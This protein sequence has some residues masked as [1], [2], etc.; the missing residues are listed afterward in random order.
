MVTRPSAPVRSQRLSAPT[1]LRVRA[2]TGPRRTRQGHGTRRH[3][4]SRDAGTADAPGLPMQTKALDTPTAR[5][6]TLLLYALLGGTT[7]ALAAVGLASCGSANRHDL[8]VTSYSPAE[9]AHHDQQIEVRFDRPVVSE[10]EVGGD[11]VPSM[12]VLEPAVAWRGHW[13]DRQTLIIEPLAPLARVD[14][15]RGPARRRAAAPRRRLPLRVRAPAAGHRR[16]RRRRRRRDRSHRRAAGDVQPAGQRR[17]RRAALRA[18]PGRRGGRPGGARPGHVRPDDRPAAGARARARRRARAALPG[19]DRR[20]GRRR[21]RRDGEPGAAGPPDARRGRVGPVGLGRRRRRGR[22]HRRACHRGVARRDPRRDQGQPGD[23]RPGQR[24]ARR[25][26][27][28]LPGGRRSRHRDRLRDLA[29]RPGRRP[30]RGADRRRRRPAVPHR[31]RPSADL[32][33][34]RPL[35]A[36]GLGAKRLPGVV[37]QR[38]RVRRWTARGSRTTRS[39][40]C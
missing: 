11:V 3:S 8:T 17:R 23:P 4:T 7:A 6:R 32:D 16:R 15:L 37:A 33:G 29:D 36:R 34:A 31:R 27:P 25:Q 1:H 26:R 21:D 12:I 13:Q 10:G 14:P 38:P 19:P 20:P 5:G 22:D 40:R 39:S 2:A 18:A 24:F 30:R 9:G 28:S 35:R